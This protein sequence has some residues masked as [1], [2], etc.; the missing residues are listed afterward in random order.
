MARDI[1]NR[2]EIRAPLTGV[3]QN[4]QFHTIGGVV[5]AGEP[6]LELVPVNDTLHI[7]ARIDPVDINHVHL[8]AMAEV[9]FPGFKSRT[10]PLILGTIRSVSADSKVD[11]AT[12]KPY[13]LAIVEVKDKDI[14]PEY[15]GKLTAGMPAEMIIAVGERTVADYLISPLTDFARTSMREL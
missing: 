14:P 2:L 13:F 9:R 11:E 12:Q 15:R 7:E 6:I 1:V 10:F 5:R 3:V 8:E 4:L